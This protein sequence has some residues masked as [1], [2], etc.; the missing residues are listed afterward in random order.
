[1]AC[2]GELQQYSGEAAARAKLELPSVQISLL[3]ALK[4]TGKPVVSVVFGGR[5]Q[6]LTEVEQYAD[7][8]LYAWQPGTE[9]GNAI[10]NLLFGKATPSAKLTMSFPRTTGQCPIYYNSFATGKPKALDTLEGSGYNSSYR[11][12]LNKPLYPFGFGLSY[13]DFKI[14]NLQL[15][16][17]TIKAGDVVT[18]TVDLTNTG[19]RSTF[20]KENRRMSTMKSN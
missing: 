12:E 9:G 11:D 5:P 16:K 20:R 17:K 4:K 13:T 14:E 8:I 10:A 2:I 3:K 15:S 1:M 7:A 18:A 19:T 6:V